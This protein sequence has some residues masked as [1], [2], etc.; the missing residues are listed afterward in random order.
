MIFL[1]DDCIISELRWPS[2]WEFRCIATTL[3]N[4]LDRNARLAIGHMAGL[5]VSIVRRGMVM[6]ILKLAGT[7]ASESE[8]LMICVNKGNRMSIVSHQA[9]WDRIL[10]ACCWRRKHNVLTSI[11][12]L[13][14]S[15]QTMVTM[16]TDLCNLVFDPPHRPHTWLFG[17]WHAYHW[18]VSKPLW[19]FCQKINLNKVWHV[20]R[21]SCWE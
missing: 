18:R 13:A 4:I 12:L 2:V 11:I 19:T 7:S 9:H 15:S 20:E 21:S 1:L 17:K 10:R 14:D 3:S 6:V 5:R 16:G 8:R